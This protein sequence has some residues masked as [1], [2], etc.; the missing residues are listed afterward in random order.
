MA[1]YE[2]K[3]PYG[4]GFLLVDEI[5]E[6][7][8]NAMTITT[9]WEVKRG[10]QLHLAGHF[11]RPDKPIFPG[12]M[13][14]QLIA[15]SA[16]L[17]GFRISGLQGVNFNGTI[18]PGEILATAYLHS[19]KPEYEVEP[20]PCQVNGRLTKSP[21]KVVCQV[22]CMYLETTE[23]PTT[24]L[25]KDPAELAGVPHLYTGNEILFPRGP[26][27]PNSVLAEH[28]CQSVVAMNAHTAAF[29]GKKFFLTGIPEANFFSDVP[30]GDTV[31]S[32]G[33]IQ[34]NQQDPRLGVAS[35]ETYLDEAPIAM[36]EMSFAAV[37]S[38]QATPA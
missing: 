20:T 13:G 24:F 28:M 4:I 7:N 9:S 32:K 8:S 16:G 1:L 10:L 37:R 31:V 29:Q 6:L 35:V 5:L 15:E 23:E 2:L 34:L 14:I 22:H 18:G 36:M 30:W 27:L 11:P 3:M 12:V 25:L 17:P 38:R 21:G 19:D 26:A 33:R